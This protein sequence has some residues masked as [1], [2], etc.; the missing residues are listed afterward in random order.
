MSCF[1]IK[2][3][4]LLFICSG[5]ILSSD[6]SKRYKKSSGYK[7]HYLVRPSKRKVNKF[8]L[9]PKKPSVPTGADFPV[10]EKT[11]TVAL[12][13]D[14]FLALGEPKPE[15][16]LPLPSKIIGPRRPVESEVGKSYSLFGPS[17]IAVPAPTDAAATSLLPE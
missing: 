2:L 17:P 10:L 1:K 12:T 3:L 4:L 5:Q 13:R 7:K 15:S 11:K 14:Y 9:P 8:A 6:K 16:K